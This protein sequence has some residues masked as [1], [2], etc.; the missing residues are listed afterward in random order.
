MVEM[1]SPNM[2]QGRIKNVRVI[3]VHDM[4]VPE[5]EP[6][7]AEA[8]AR[9]FQNPARRASA[10]S[11]VDTDSDVTGV[12]D[13]D[14]AWAAPGANADGLQ[15]EL[16]GYARQSSAEWQDDDSLKILENAARRC[17]EWV[18]KFG[19]PVRHLSVAELADGVTMGFV[20]HIDVTNAFHQTDH[21]DPGPNFPWD[22]FLDRV[23][24]LL[25]TVPPPPP[26]PLPPTPDPTG[27]YAMHRLDLQ[28]AQNAPVTDIH[29]DNLQGLLLAAGY[30]PK[31]LVDPNTG[32]PDG[33]AGKTTKACVGDWQVKTNT[34]DGHGH[35]DFIVGV[36]TWKSLIEY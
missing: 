18:K 19:V 27:E 20:G 36:G 25:G 32:R 11:C 13:E 8:V 28:N 15:I 33:I 9:V 5:T 31:G 12:H 3:V 4:E 30:G 1:L 10:H 29:V 7:A 17:A 34:G 16:A 2:Y 35:A 21:W 14:T 23:N 26:P 6:N 22:Y 24:A